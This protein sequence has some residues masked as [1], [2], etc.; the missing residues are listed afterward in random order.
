VTA[1]LR[2]LIGSPLLRALWILAIVVALLATLLPLGEQAPRFAYADKVFHGGYFALLGGLAVLAPRQL[3]S[4]PRAALGMV[5]LGI[6]IELIQAF[7]PW[8][9]FEWLDI[10]ADSAG[11]LIGYAIAG[12]VR[13]QS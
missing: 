4:A 11:V 5:G 8:R 3:A 13:R 6:A 7:L 1:V 2:G 12:R 9:S 10:A